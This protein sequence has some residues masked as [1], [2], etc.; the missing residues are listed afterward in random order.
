MRLKGAPRG[1]AWPQIR[2]QLGRQRAAGGIL[3]LRPCPR[4]ARRRGSPHAPSRPLVRILLI[5]D[6]SETAAYVARGLKEQGHLVERAMSEAEAEALAPAG[7]WDALIL[8][9]MLAGSGDGLALLARL[10]GA[11][12]KAPVL[13]LSALGSVEERVRGLARGA[14]DYLAKPFA[15]SELMA[16]LEALARRPPP[17]AGAGA[18]GEPV[19]LEVG[20]LV[21][22]LLARTA[23]RGGV[24]L[25]LLPRE[26][27]LLA[28]LARHAGRTVTRT[29]LLEQV[30]GYHFDPQSGVIDSH[31]SRLRRKLDRGAA[32]PP[33]AHRARG[34]LPPR[35]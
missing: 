2:L 24:R 6:D 16:R 9:R 32:R 22:D 10:R 5:E 1:Q 18:G 34:W 25:D 4:T 13:V 21:L 29:M 20:D 33:P 28:F 19:R 31:I 30:W 12:L 15:F 26:F 35:R 11:G 8:D 17:A 3:R 23:E 7:P 14:D 27:Q